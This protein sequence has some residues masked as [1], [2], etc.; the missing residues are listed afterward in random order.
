VLPVAPQQQAA[1]AKR[2]MLPIVVLVL[3]AAGAA[4]GYFY[5]QSYMAPPSEGPQAKE[6]ARAPAEPEQPS[7]ATAAPG[8]PAPAAQAAPAQPASPSAAPTAQP[9]APV[10]TVEVEVSSLPRDSD[11]TVDGKRVGTTP[12]HVSL[13]VGREAQIVVS[14]PGYASMSK[15]VVAGASTEPLRFKLEPLPFSLVVQTT[16][17]EANVSVGRATA[18]APAPLDLGHLDGGVQ[19]SIAKDG[20]QRMTRLVRLD[21]FAEKDGVMRAEI[22]V[23]LS[24]LPGFQGVPTKAVPKKHPHAGSPREAPPAP[25]EAEA[26]PEA[27]SEAPAE[28]PSGSTSKP[29]PEGRAP[30]PAAPFA[31]AAP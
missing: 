21:E 31:P 23:T 8:A 29:M 10:A 22:E 13:P 9:A 26:A 18:T 30:E 14:S 16:P 7:E 12:K 24:P 25:G 3:L 2:S 27:P 1:A 19:V 28:K 20:F 6:K 17:P 5:Y 4:G 11:I 15:R